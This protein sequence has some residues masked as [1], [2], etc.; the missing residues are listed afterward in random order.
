MNANLDKTFNREFYFQAFICFYTI[1]VDP[2]YIMKRL[3]KFAVHFFNFGG[4]LSLKISGNRVKVSKIPAVFHLF[5]VLF[6]FICSQLII[7]SRASTYLNLNRVRFESISVISATASSFM[8]ILLNLLTS[9]VIIH[10][11]FKRKQVLAFFKSL[12]RIMKI[13]QIEIN[14]D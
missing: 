3:H 4:I 6:C 13:L 2:N 10:Q 7:S 1:S 8:R 9:L 14:S 11:Y 5:S 12:G